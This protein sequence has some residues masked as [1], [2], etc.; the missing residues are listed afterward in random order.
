MKRAFGN[1]CFKGCLIYVVALAII[2]ALSAAGLG[3]LGAR[4]GAG[5]RNAKPGQAASQAASGNGAAPAS[6]AAANGQAG[7]PAQSPTR[8]L[9][10]SPPRTRAQITRL[11]PPCRARARTRNLDG[12]WTM[13]DGRWTIVP[14]L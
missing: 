8:L 7:A 4:F 3:G 13:D 14:V 9:P 12:R 10:C 5:A 11:H 1:S 2:L 6:G